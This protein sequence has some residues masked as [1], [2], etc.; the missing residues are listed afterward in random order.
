MNN[1]SHIYEVRARY[2]EV[3]KM[4]VVYHSH[5]FEWFEAARTEM[6][7]TIGLPYAQ[8]EKDELSLPVVEAQCKYQK[9]I[10]Y[11]EL[12]QI[13]TR[14]VEVSRSK[15]RLAYKVLG[16]DNTDLRA[17]GYTIHCYIGREGKAVRAPNKLYNFL[18]KFIS[19]GEF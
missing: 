13:E 14:M 5:H 2:A 8:L 1:S 18:E 7:R 10:L 4:G 17:E 6:L 12:M 15:I 16:N 19:E 11:D 9:P 3:D